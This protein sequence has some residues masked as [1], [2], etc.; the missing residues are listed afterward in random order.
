MA[1]R[2]VKARW[3]Q[4]N[5]RII[6]ASAP[7]HAA[8]VLL[9]LAL[10]LKGSRFVANSRGADN[11]S[12]EGTEHNLLLQAHLGGKG[13]DALVALDR[14][15]ESETNTSVAAWGVSKATTDD[16]CTGYILVGS[17]TTL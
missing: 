6:V 12:A 8:S 11:L 5:S 10:S 3:C 15:R 7:T 4:W 16:S 13:D 14:T 17:I 9:M 2:V 1:D